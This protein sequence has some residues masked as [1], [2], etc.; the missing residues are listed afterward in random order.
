M[1]KFCCVLLANKRQATYESILRIV[2]VKV[3][4]A[5]AE[6]FNPQRIIVDFEVALIQA[7][8]IELPAS[9]IEGCFFH[10]CKSL[11]RHIQELGLSRPYLEN[12]NVKQLLRYVMALGFLP[13]NFVRICYRN[14][15]DAE[16]TDQVIQQLPNLA[17]FFAYFE[18]TWMNNNG[19]FPIALWNVY[20][21]ERWNSEPI[22]TLKV[23]TTGMSFWM[24]LL[25]IISKGELYYAS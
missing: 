12:P 4:D 3:R 22:I 25:F 14:I 20:E 7:L 18:E 11:W 9:R 6:E 1:L 2:K 16:E 13:V 15:R 17:H 10:F 19:I 21:R 8:R 23:I 5:T 24:I